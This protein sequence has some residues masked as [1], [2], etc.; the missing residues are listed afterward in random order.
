MQNRY[1]FTRALRLLEPAIYSDLDF[2]FVLQI[3]QESVLR[4]LKQYLNIYNKNY[5]VPQNEV[6]VEWHF[7]VSCLFPCCS[8]CPHQ[9]SNSDVYK[10]MYVKVP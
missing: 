1:I 9:T 7:V 3:K 6:N 4:Q 10:N 2:E 8:L 5:L